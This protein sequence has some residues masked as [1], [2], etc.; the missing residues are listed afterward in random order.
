MHEEK[1]HISPGIFNTPKLDKC[2]ILDQADSYFHSTLQPKN[3]K[4]ITPHVMC[5]LW[6]CLDKWSPCF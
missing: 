2:E 4:Q 1:R 5:K 3:T 6:S